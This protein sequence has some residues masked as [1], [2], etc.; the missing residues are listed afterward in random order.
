LLLL[1]CKRHG[2][3][4]GALGALL[5]LAQQSLCST[6]N[7]LLFLAAAAAWLVTAIVAVATA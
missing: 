2:C 4:R 6:C 1:L 5:L 7:S 3:C